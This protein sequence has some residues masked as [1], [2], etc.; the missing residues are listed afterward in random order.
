[1]ASLRAYF[2]AIWL[3]C[4]VNRHFS[5]YQ[6]YEIKIEQK[7]PEKRLRMSG[8]KAYFKNIY[9]DLIILNAFENFGN[10]S[11]NLSGNPEILVNLFGISEISEISY[12]F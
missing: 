10:P 1:M 7:L 11:A 3:A 5:T 4:W 6:Y 8:N 9:D 12:A 2:Q